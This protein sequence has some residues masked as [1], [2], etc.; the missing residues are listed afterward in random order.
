[1]AASKGSAICN[2]HFAWW[3]GEE[4][5]LCCLI[6]KYLEVH[7]LHPL[8]A[9]H[10][11]DVGC[12]LCLSM[13]LNIHAPVVGH[14]SE[15]LIPKILQGEQLRIKSSYIYYGAFLTSP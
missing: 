8:H 4:G 1:M 11:L 6:C 13:S 12:S 9:L 5:L 15:D 14:P 2:A 7:A 10:V 3:K